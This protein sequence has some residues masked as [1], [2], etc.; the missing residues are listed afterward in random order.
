MAWIIYC[1]IAALI[2]ALLKSHAETKRLNRQPQKSNDHCQEL[3]EINGPLEDRLIG[4]GYSPLD[5]FKD[6]PPRST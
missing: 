6:Q 1:I 2:G 4:L 5:G 3:W